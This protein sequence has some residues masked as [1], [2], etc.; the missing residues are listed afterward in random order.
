MRAARFH[1]YGGFDEVAVEEVPDPQPGEGELLLRV[2][3]SGVNPFD[4]K[5]LHGVYA[6][7]APLPAPRGLGVDVAGVVERVGPGVAGVT[8]GQELLGMATS[9]AF[10]ELAL[11]RPEMLVAKPPEVSWEIAGSLGVVVGTAYATLAQLGLRAGE[12]LLLAGAAGMV[13]QVATQ[14]AVARGV[15]VVGSA[16]ERNQERVRELG[17]VAVPYGDGLAQR[18]REAAPDGADAGLDTS[19]HGELAAMLEVLGSPQRLI[20]IGNAAEAQRLGV[21]F[22]AGGGGELTLPALREVLPLIAS[23]RFS[24]PIAGVYDLGQVGDALRESELVHPAGKLVIV[25]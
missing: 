16:S 22:H 21:A 2:K 9:P 8:P 1:R 25:P 24:I 12:T 13:G 6:G 4:W 17:A 20:T 14:L 11:G 23:G 10:A 7:G 18:F 3:A 5:M 15:N 19:G